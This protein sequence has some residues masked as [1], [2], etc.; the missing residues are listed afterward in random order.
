MDDL[1]WVTS[2]VTIAD[3]QEYEYNPRYISKDSYE[4]LV[5]SIRQDG[6]HQRIICDE[7]GVI[8]GG[9]QRLK[10]M[11]EAGYRLSDEIEVLT[12]SRALTKD[13]FDRINIRDNIGYGDWDM[14]ILSS[15]FSVDELVSIGFDKGLLPEMPDIDEININDSGG[16]SKSR[17]CQCPNC[18]HIF[19]SNVK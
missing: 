3:L 15:R 7:N 14:D 10:A 11:I 12:P 1:T 17:E 2:K 19:D 8:I 13:E 4:K 5:Q 9:H 16:E 6:Y 18:G